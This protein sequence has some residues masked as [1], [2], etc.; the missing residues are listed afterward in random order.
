[1]MVRAVHLGGCDVDRSTIALYVAGATAAAAA[2][3]G[4]TQQPDMYAF[5]DETE[6]LHP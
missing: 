1:M 3:A 4:V 2:P 6:Q 5:V